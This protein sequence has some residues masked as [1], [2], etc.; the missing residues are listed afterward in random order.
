MPGLPGT[1]SEALGMP[2]V[3]QSPGTASVR[4]AI[5]HPAACALVVV[6]AGV[7]RSPRMGWISTG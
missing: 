2:T 6:S 4:V 7:S 5:Q 1:C 3:A